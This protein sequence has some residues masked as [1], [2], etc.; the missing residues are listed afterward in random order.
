ML[1]NFVLCSFV[2]LQIHD[3][4]LVTR[5]DHKASS[6]YTH[7]KY[8]ESEITVYVFT[9]HVE[10]YSKYKLQI[11]MPCTPD[12]TYQYLYH[13]HF[14]WCISRATWMQYCTN[15]IYGYQKCLVCIANW[16][17][18]RVRVRNYCTK[19]N[20]ETFLLPTKQ[21]I[22][23]ISPTARFGFQSFANIRRSVFVCQQQFYERSYI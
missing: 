22:L 12:I 19:V 5:I 3:K 15:T 1:P 16:P 4:Y 20:K 14:P 6:Q 18:R 2:S 7:F 8:S 13:I 17:V 10:D 21:S 9:L 23:R 11:L